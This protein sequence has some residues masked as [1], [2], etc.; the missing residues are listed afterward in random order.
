MSSVTMGHKVLNS[1]ALVR[2]QGLDM[3]IGTFAAGTAGGSLFTAVDGSYL[4]KFF[5]VTSVVDGGIHDSGLIM[6]GTLADVNKFVGRAKVPQTSVL[7]DVH[8]TGNR[9]V[10][11]PGNSFAWESTAF[12]S[13]GLVRLG[14]GESLIYT[15]IAEET[16]AGRGIPW[17]EL[18]PEARAIDEAR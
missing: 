15:N 14:R 3:V 17:V 5:G 2:V 6:L 4:I 7:G 11:V 12:D 13:D 10:Q 16:S 8:G 1:R 9:G 18:I